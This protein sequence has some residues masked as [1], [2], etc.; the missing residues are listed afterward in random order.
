MSQNPS[1]QTL[2]AAVILGV[3][4]VAG[5]VLIRISVDNAAHEVAGLREVL[6]RGGAPGP[7]PQ[8]AAQ[9][10]RPDPNRRYSINTQG[11]PSKGNPDAKLAIVEFSD[12]QCPFCRR[13]T[14]TLAQIEREYGDK[15][16]IVF[17][18][19]PLE[20]HPKA[21]AAHAAAE[22]A[23]QQ[24]KFWEMHDLIFGNQEAM[25]PEKYVEYAKQLNL[26][27][28]RFQKD[29]A[30]AEIKARIEADEAEGQKLGL[31]G[32]PSFFVNG[33]YLSGA[34]PFDVFKQLIDQELGKV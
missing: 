9:P 27:V 22:A 5:A 2:V 16:R 28:D 25:S 7:A 29:V 12:F 18:H 11:A 6:A 30:S 19:M 33:R 10:G 34:Q 31:S 4:I 20:M 3:A 17:K 32:T 23:H 8:A 26:D 1:G 21:P 24:G 14:P 15:V 13:V